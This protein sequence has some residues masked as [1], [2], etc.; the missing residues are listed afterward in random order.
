MGYR[1]DGRRKRHW[2]AWVARNRAALLSSGEP[3]GQLQ[4]I[5]QK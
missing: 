1:R 2:D 4:Q 5:M 3:S